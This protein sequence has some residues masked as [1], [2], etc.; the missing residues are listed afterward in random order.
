MFFN[1]MLCRLFNLLYYVLIEL[2]PFPERMW[3]ER[4]DWRHLWGHMSNVRRHM[5]ERGCTSQRAIQLYTGCFIKQLSLDIKTLSPTNC[6]RNRPASLI[7]P[8]PRS[9][10]PMHFPTYFSCPWERWD[11]VTCR[12][13]CKFPTLERHTYFIF[14]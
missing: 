9:F 12:H 8:V 6:S 4:H 7:P 5:N 11:L 14:K 10:S 3:I 1:Y 13:R 2:F